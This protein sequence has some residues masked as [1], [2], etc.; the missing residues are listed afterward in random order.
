MPAGSPT[1]HHDG[2]RSP[3]SSDGS[4]RSDAGSATWGEED[5]AAA[6]ADVV[7]WQGASGD[8]SWDTQDGAAAAAAGRPGPTF[9]RGLGEVRYCVRDGKRRA[10][11][12]SVRAA[13]ITDDGLL[14]PLPHLASSPRHHVAPAWDAEPP[15]AADAAAA[16]DGG[17]ELEAAA[18]AAAPMNLHNWCVRKRAPPPARACS[19]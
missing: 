4:S 7:V 9:K 5:P 6:A 19:R 10:T 16:D 15:A 12:F 8:A 14:V 17:G 11:G 2:H 18:A 1:A 3:T 13:R